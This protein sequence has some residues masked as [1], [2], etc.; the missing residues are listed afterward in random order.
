MTFKKWKEQ[1]GY[2]KAH[3]VGRSCFTCK[4]APG[5]GSYIQCLKAQK[6]LGGLITTRVAWTSVCI[7]WA[8]K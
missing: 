2:F 5:F 7:Y 4:H 3:M 1:A 6:E 8:K